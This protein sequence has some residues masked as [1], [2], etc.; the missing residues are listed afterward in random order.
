[1]FSSSR[2]PGKRSIVGSR[3]CVPYG[4]MYRPGVIQACAGTDAYLVA[5]DVGGGGGGADSGGGAGDDRGGAGSGGDRKTTKTFAAGDIVGA[6]FRSVCRN[7][8]PAGQVVYVTHNGREVRG[9]VVVAAAVGET[10]TNQRPDDAADDDDDCVRVAVAVGASE[11]EMELLCRVEDV[12]LMES[13][14]SARLLDQDADSGVRLVDG[15]VPA[16]AAVGSMSSETKK[17]AVS[18]VVGVP[19]AKHR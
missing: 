14:K 11:C 6:G 1:M 13:R 4:G 2:R 17:R 5:F 9:R 19:L 10:T 12:R 3:V 15:P 18:N 7:C 16:C 8:L